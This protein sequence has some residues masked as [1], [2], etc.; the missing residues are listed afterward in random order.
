MVSPDGTSAGLEGDIAE[1]CSHFGSVE[2]VV[3]VPAFE[4]ASAQDAVRVFIK[5]QDAASAV[6][7]KPESSI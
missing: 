2:R 4:N 7:G 5:F 1:E 6:L 3:L